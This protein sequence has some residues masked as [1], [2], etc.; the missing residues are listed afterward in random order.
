MINVTSLIKATKKPLLL[1][2]HT[3]TTIQSRERQIKLE[4][5]IKTKTYK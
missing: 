4:P 5:K 3:T 1:S 2:I